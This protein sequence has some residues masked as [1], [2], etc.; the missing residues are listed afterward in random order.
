VE[1]KF[2]TKSEIQ[3]P[4]SGLHTAAEIAIAFKPALCLFPSGVKTQI[5]VCISYF[6]MPAVH[7]SWVTGCD[8]N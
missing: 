5:I 6:P 8:G 7:K 2:G 4:I 1:N 3:P